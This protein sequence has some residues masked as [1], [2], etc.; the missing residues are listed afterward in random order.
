MCVWKIISI[1]YGNNLILNEENCLNDEGW[2]RNE[3]VTFIYITLLNVKCVFYRFF[4][5]EMFSM[6]NSSILEI[7]MISVTFI[8]HFY[9]MFVLAIIIDYLILN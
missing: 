5:S 2:T 3:L 7:T 6:F 9:Y 4:L 1:I 8:F